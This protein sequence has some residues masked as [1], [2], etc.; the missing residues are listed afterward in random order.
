MVVGM[1][2]GK[3]SCVN[4]MTDVI[5]FWDTRYILQKKNVIQELLNMSV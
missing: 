1:F 2:F 4:V 3:T 5:T